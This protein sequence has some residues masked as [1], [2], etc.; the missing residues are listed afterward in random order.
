MGVFMLN[1][2]DHMKTPLI[3]FM[4]LVLYHRVPATSTYKNQIFF[5]TS[6]TV[7]DIFYLKLILPVHLYYIPRR[8]LNDLLRIVCALNNN[9]TSFDFC[10]LSIIALFYF[11]KKCMGVYLQSFILPIIF[12]ICHDQPSEAMYSMTFY[13][14]RTLVP[15]NNYHQTRDFVLPIFIMFGVKR[16]C[17]K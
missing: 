12:Y 5:N 9:N 7:T 16:D 3:M 10:I 8:I 11:C 17:I 6:D 15:F 1:P 13:R 4:S 14:F 2:E